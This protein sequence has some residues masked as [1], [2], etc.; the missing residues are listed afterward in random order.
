M[1]A[2]TILMA[3]VGCCAVSA[4]FAES[5][6]EYDLVEH[7]VLRGGESSGAHFD[8]VM[9]ELGDA[10]T[11]WAKRGLTVQVEDFGDSP[12]PLGLS[13]NV[14]RDLPPRRQVTISSSFLSASGH[15]SF[16]GTAGQGSDPALGPPMSFMRRYAGIDN[17][18]SLYSGHW[19][20][21]GNDASQVFTLGYTWRDVQLEGSAFAGRDHEERMP[22]AADRL[23]IDSRSARLTFKPT[24]K[25]SVQFS[26]GTL[27]ALDQVVAGGD[28]RRTTLSSTYRHSF[29]FGEWES[30]LAWGRNSRRSRESTVGYLAE[31]SLRLQQT[32]VFFGRVERVGSDELLRQNESFQRTPFKLSKLTLGYFQ[33][34]KATPAISMDVGLLVSRYLVPSHVT[35]SYG[36]DPTGCMAFVRLK[37]R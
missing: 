23:K 36:D 34:V 29:E 10:A 20:H 35:P 19:L 12:V 21:G 16:S 14:E 11:P 24:S 27:G 25:W 26:K 5:Q 30:T 4:S 13:E 3:S 15:H 28:V 6:L 18:D 33:D 2:L 7:I 8:K 31:S 37:F 22:P 9:A 1:R 17:P 32:H